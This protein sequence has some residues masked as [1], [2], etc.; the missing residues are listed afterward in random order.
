M[1]LTSNIDFSLLLHLYL[2]SLRIVTFSACATF[3][4]LRVTF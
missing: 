3:R 4:K 2:K 1:C